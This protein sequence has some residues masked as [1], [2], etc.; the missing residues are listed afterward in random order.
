V[1][2]RDADRND[3]FANPGPAVDE[4]QRNER[5]DHSLRDEVENQKSR[6]VV[7]GIFDLTIMHS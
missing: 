3:K 1:A 5:I 6:P 2:E 4:R 7:G